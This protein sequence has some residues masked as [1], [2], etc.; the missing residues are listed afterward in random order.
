M[1]NI[2]I[3][4]L[5]LSLS[6]G[7]SAQRKRRTKLPPPPTQEEL[8]EQLRAEKYDH[9]LQTIERVVFIDSILVNKGE[10]VNVLP[11][12]AE[13]GKVY[14][15]RDYFNVKGK[16]T[17]DCTVFCSQ[18]GDRIIYAQQNAHGVMQLYGSEM[19]GGNWGTAVPL[20][21]LED[22]VSMNYPYLLNDGV[23]LYYASKGEESIGGYDIFMTRWDAENQRFLKPEN[24]GMPFNSQ[25]NDYLYVVDE[26]NQLGWFVTD[27]GQ[28][29]DTVCVYCFIPNDSRHIYNAHEMER[30]SLV[31]LA[32]ISC[33]RNTWTDMKQV[34]E[35]TE[36]LNIL[37]HSSQRIANADFNFIINDNIVY[38]S[39]QQFRHPKSKELIKDWQ[40]RKNELVSTS[41]LLEKYREDVHLSKE[42]NNISIKELIT[43]L[44]QK[45]A[46]AIS[47]IYAIEK[48]IRTFEQR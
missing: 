35:A 46:K 44:E 10:V 15:Y 39:P 7:V 26:F 30:D 8:A 33:I 36:R 18:L 27:R 47:D 45:Q 42:T 34:K 3:F 41:E 43:E 5:L 17:P 31:S 1:R 37:K 13:N 14:P 32:N 6:L 21:G 28:S 12:G 4:T 9:K 25:A 22:S 38:T 23:T 29:G 20:T 11:L 48:E 16:D 40:K 24:I 19:I 2:V